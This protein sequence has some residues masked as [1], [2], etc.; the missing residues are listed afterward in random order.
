MSYEVKIDASPIYEL[1]GSFMVYVTKKWVRDLDVGTAWIE[2]VDNKLSSDAKQAIDTARDLPFNDYDVLYA[3]AFTRPGFD[4]I[5]DFLAYLESSDDQLLFERVF[6]HLPF[7]TPEESV[8][9]R[10]TYTP[11]L[12]AW[13]K[14]YFRQQEGE[15][16]AIAFEDAE[17]KKMLLGKMDPDALVEYATSGLVVPPLQDLDTVVL[18]PSAHNR[19]I[20]TYCF[21][22]RMLLI[23]Y[24]VDIPEENEDEP[25]TI[26]LRL[27]RAVADPQRLRLLRYFAGEPKSLS[28]MRRDL[29][30]ADEELM[31]DLMILRVAGLLRIHIGRY[32]KEKFS[33]RPEG[34]SDLQMFLESYVRI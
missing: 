32:G 33:I 4:E 18:F 17:E 34:T 11:L 8:R 25:P 30:Q 23:Q 6:H 7:L 3:W 27:T 10:R 19:P 15:L 16:R 28:D 20:N 5:A 9:I 26:L 24:P 13:D 14:E 29:K 1:L 21:Y 31:S 2:Q 12:R 22:S